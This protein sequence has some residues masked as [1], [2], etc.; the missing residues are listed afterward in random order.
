MV[1]NRNANSVY[2]WCREASNPN[3]VDRKTYQT[4]GTV[5]ID[6]TVLSAS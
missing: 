6:I 4:C 3:S 2:V 5:C 1:C